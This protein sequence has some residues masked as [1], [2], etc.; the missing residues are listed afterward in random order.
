MKEGRKGACHREG[1]GFWRVMWK[2]A[3]PLGVCA[4]RSDDC[5]AHRRS[6]DP[7][8]AVLTT[9]LFSP[10]APT[11]RTTDTLVITL[12]LVPSPPPPST[13]QHSPPPPSPLPVLCPH[14][15]PPHPH[16]SHHNSRRLAQ[17][18]TRSITWATT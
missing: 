5:E 2:T 13:P 4:H 9:V 1:N 8:A 3:C 14:S 6:T 12:T 18:Y 16:E 11:P 7:T 15:S 10:P 17:G